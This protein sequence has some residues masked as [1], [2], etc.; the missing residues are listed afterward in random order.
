VRFP[1]R[2]F[3]VIPLVS[4]A[5]GSVARAEEPLGASPSASAPAPAAL[6]ADL[7]P[8]AARTNAIVAGIATTAVAYGL[9]LSTSLLVEERDFRGA[10]DLRIPIVGPWLTLSKAGCPESDTNCSTAPL[11][12]GAILTIFD[13]VAQ[14][15][16]L[17]I[18]GEG[19]FLK[20][21]SG[22]P[23]QKAEGPTV[24]AVPLNFEKGGV[25]LGVLGTF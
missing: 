16:G 8:P 19:L 14:A 21:S 15:G 9:A 25:G 18:I 2:C 24:R 22:R 3:A 13:G 5:F 10:K 4:F 17:G 11:V 6:P 20:T 1:S 23:A 12:I 7:P